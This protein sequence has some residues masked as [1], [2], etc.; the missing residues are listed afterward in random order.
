MIG[1]FGAV[2]ITEEHRNLIKAQKANISAKLGI[3]PTEFEIIKVHTQVVAG[4][5]YFFHLKCGSGK[6]WSVLLFEPLPHTG[7][8]VTITIAEAGHT[9]ARCE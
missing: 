7:N 4:T 6:E 2:E 9:A 3:E 1:G 5:N 8:P